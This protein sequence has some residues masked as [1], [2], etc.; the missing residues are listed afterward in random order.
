MPL[1]SHLL[2]A[3]S[4]TF[5]PPVCT[6]ARTSIDG[7]L[8]TTT[9]PKTVPAKISAGLAQPSPAQLARC[10]RPPRRVLETKHLHAFLSCHV[11]GTRRFR[12]CKSHHISHR[13][14]VSSGKLRV[15]VHRLVGR[16]RLLPSTTQSLIYIPFP[17]SDPSLGNLVGRGSCSPF[18]LPSIARRRTF[19]LVYSFVFTH[20]LT[21][22]RRVYFDLSVSNLYTPLSI[23]SRSQ[24]LILFSDPTYVTAQL[25]PAS[26]TTTSPALNSIT[27][28]TRIR[29]FALTTKHLPS[30]IRLDQLDSVNQ[31]TVDSCRRYHWD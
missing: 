4:V 10:P 7:H 8:L 6:A 26:Y 19:A 12:I 18:P 20:L 29:H 25:D 14:P 21:H 31:P 2:L 22:S 16:L 30:R 9:P 13:T 23:V 5:S 17:S 24:S 27:R 28:I 1:P 3:S 15:K 11:T